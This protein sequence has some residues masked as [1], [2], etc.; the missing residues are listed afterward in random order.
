MINL[1]ANFF[2]LGGD[3][4]AATRVVRGLHAKHHG[5]MDSRNLGG[6]TGTLDGL[7]AA[8]Y[9]LK[10]ETLGAY[11]EFL[12]S[13]SAFQTIDDTITV[14]T[15]G[16]EIGVNSTPGYNLKEN[17]TD[18]LYVS[19]LES[20][21]LGY[22]RVA[23]SL[24]DLGGVDPNTQSCQG[25]LGKVS[26]RQQRRSVFKSGPLHLACLRG[27]PYL[28]RKLLEKGRVCPCRNLGCLLD[29]AFADHDSMI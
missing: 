12:A 19:L 7:F 24:L 8:K 2:A 17:V 13:K 20:I 26:D 23:C 18:P 6:G 10:S 28:V 1:D 4:L 21:T 11:I 14:G 22:T 5:V 3:S 9:L 27:D 25:R 15:E 29:I 16:E